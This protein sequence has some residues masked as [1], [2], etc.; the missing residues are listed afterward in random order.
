MKPGATTFAV[1]PRRA[2]LA[3]E[4]AGE[5]DEAALGRGVVDLAGRAVEADDARDQDDAAPAGAQHALR[6]ALDD[7]ERAA[8]VRRDDA[9]EVVLG[10]AQQQRVLGDAGVRDDDL[11][12]T[13]RA[14]DLG[15]GGIDGCG[16]RH[17]RAHRERA[18]GTLAG[19]RGHGDLVAG[20][21]EAL[22]DRAA[23]AAV[24]AGDEDDAI[25]GH[26]DAPGGS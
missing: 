14:L 26:D 12:R 1:M 10:H 20:G 25:G 19:A 3:G 21:D 17:I 15:E 16:I 24:S 6:R 9:V 23:D 5:A 18:L 4:R 22:G 2:E 13:E 8:E 7:A 11:D